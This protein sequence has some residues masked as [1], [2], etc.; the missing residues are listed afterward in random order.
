MPIRKIPKNYLVTT[1]RL[2]RGPN[3]QPAGWEG[4]LEQDYYVLLRDDPN[5]E[6]F[7]VQPVRVPVPKGRPYTPDVLV[8]FRPDKLG[9]RRPPELTEVKHST[10]FKKYAEKFAARFAAATAF[11]E[12]RGWIFVK[13]DESHIRIPRLSA[14]IQY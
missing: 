11:A 9:V 8:R 3:N 10:D 2:A 13:K 4:R 14:P 12:E 5:V 6:S 7:E 1:G